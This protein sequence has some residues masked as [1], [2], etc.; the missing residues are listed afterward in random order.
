MPTIRTIAAAVAVAATLAIGVPPSFAVVTYSITFDFSVSG[1]SSDLTGETFTFTKGLSDFL[2][3]GG[4]LTYDSIGQISTTSGAAATY[5]DFLVLTQNALG[6]ITSDVAGVT[7]NPPL[8]T[9]G[10]GATSINFLAPIGTPTPAATACAPHA[11]CTQTGGVSG[12][13]LFAVS[14][15]D[16]RSGSYRLVVSGTPDNG[17]VVPEPASLLLCA[18]G[19]AALAA[20][21]L[22]R[23]ARRTGDIAQND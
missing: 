7:F 9:L 16:N 18:T 13:V 10:G 21:R 20:R 19:L 23:P 2:S 6:G 11:P 4:S 22:R 15:P 3:V 12:L 8:G 1:T 14:S 17:N 5:P